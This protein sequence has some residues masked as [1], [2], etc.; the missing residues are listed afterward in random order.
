MSI[1]FLSPSVCVSLLL[2][3]HTRISKT[4]FCLGRQLGRRL[5]SFV[6]T[7]SAFLQKILNSISCCYSDFIINTSSHSLIKNERKKVGSVFRLWKMGFMQSYLSPIKFYYKE[8][9]FAERTRCLWCI[10]ERGGACSACS[11]CIGWVFS[12]VKQGLPSQ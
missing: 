8:R 11:V 6:L 4:L 5:P 3:T 2:Y 10:A 12:R 1:L 9:N 7:C